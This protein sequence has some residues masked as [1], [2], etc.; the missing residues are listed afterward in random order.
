VKSVI[1]DD[2]KFK[3][4]FL[5]IIAGPSA[6]GKSSFCIRYLQNLE[7]LCTVPTFDGGILWCYG[8]KNAFPSL[9][10]VSAKRIHLHEGVPK[11]F[12][13]K[14]GKPALII[15]DDLLTEVYSDQVC[16]LFTKGS[17]HRNISVI[18]IT[19]NLFHKCRYCRDIFL[20]SK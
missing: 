9:Q 1:H 14:E 4:P 17:H 6:S 18:F 2:L 7:S 16:H 15:I 12:E 8:E 19:L 20:N 3:H 13:N 5:C 10:S 11:N